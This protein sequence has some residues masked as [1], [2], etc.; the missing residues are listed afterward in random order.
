MPRGPDKTPRMTG[1]MS[2]EEIARRKRDLLNLLSRLQYEAA[3]LGLHIVARAIGNAVDAAG[4]EAL[5]EAAKAASYAAGHGE[6]KSAV[7]AKKELKKWREHE[8]RVAER[9]KGYVHGGE[10]QMRDAK[11][12]RKKE[13]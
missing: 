2:K 3:A 7:D 12:R 9:R 11:N 4:R 8:A 5:G 1:G 6:D 13:P 10:K